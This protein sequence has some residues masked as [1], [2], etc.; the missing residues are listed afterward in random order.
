M[1]PVRRSYDDEFEEFV[2]GASRRLLQIARLVT[3]DP[4]RAEDLTQTALVGV[5]RRWEQIRDD[6]PFAYARRSVVNAHASWWRRHRG[7]EQL[8]QDLPD[9]RSVADGTD[10]RAR[11]DVLQRALAGLTQRE[12]AVV[13]LRYFED[14][15]EQAV[16]H[17]LGIALGT[18]KSTSHRAL[19]KLRVDLDESA[20]VPLDRRRPH[21]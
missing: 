2:T 6:D 11:R 19:A 17:E 16:A 10:D 1:V 3:G 18:V 20:A 12:R 4:H 7:R 21:G 8:V 13:V 9:W 14:L 15:T 5:Y